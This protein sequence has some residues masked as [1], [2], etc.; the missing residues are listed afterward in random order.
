MIRIAISAE[1]F[2]AI[3]ATMPL[4]SVAVEPAANDRS[5]RE[6]WLDEGSSTATAYLAPAPVAPEIVPFKRAEA[7]AVALDHLFLPVRIIAHGERARH[8]IAD[9]QR[10]LDLMEQ[11]PLGWITRDRVH[12]P[13]P[14]KMLIET[15]R[16]SPR[17]APAQLRD[18][19]GTAKA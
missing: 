15:A 4:G 19:V 9:P 1:A 13:L 3:E 6:I 18:I 7:V 10:P 11:R 12:A 8:R 16:S 2:A 5:E 17:R 14:H